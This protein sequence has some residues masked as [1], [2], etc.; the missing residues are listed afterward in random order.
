MKTWEWTRRGLVL[1]AIAMAATGAIAQGAPAHVP[2]QAFFEKPAITDL[3]LS[4]S[5]RHAALV[6]TNKDERAQLVILDTTTMKP[7]VAA[8]SPT[9]DVARIRW[10]ND[11]RLLYSL[12]DPEGK[13]SEITTPAGLFAVDR[14]GGEPRDV[15]GTSSTRSFQMGYQARFLDTSW[16]QKSD[17]VFIGYP[18]MDT[19]RAM[20]HMLVRKVDTRTGQSTAMQSPARPTDWDFDP[21]GTPRFVTTREGEG[22][23]AAYL[24]DKDRK[25]WVLV[26]R[27]DAMKGEGGLSVVGFIDDNQALVSRRPAGSD[28]YALYTW[29]LKT[30]AF[31]P[32]PLLATKGFDVSVTPI[33]SN[34]KILGLR[35]T[36]DATTTAWFDEGMKAVQAKVDQ[37][38]PGTI[39]VIGVPVRPEV[40]VVAVFSFSDTDP[41][42]Y[43]LYD[44]KAQKLIPIGQRRPSIDPSRM[45]RKDFVTYKARDGL[46]IPAWVTTPRDGKKGPRPMVVL[47][48]GG[49][50]V[51]GGHW[52]WEPMAQFLASRGYVVLEPEYRGSTGFGFNHFKASWKQ[53]GLKMQ[54][55]VAD[56]T[57]WAISKGLADPGRI[58]IAGASYG[59][60]ATLMGLVNDPDLYKCGIDWVGVTDI[61]LLYSVAWSDFN[62]EYAQY[63]MPVLVADREKDAAQIKATSPIQQA[64]RIKHPLLMAYGGRDVRV[65][66]THGIDFRDAVTKTNQNVEW[67]AYPDEG[68][69]WVMLKN[70]V[71]FWTRVEKFLAKN[72]GQ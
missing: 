50:W 11:K 46:E 51:R 38:L 21:T 29:D 40:P 19:R 64:A 39:N 33:R 47:V 18:Q 62:D 25:E 8:A 23:A 71:D 15:T 14:D 36:T 67:V 56:G 1:G 32:E 12:A 48:H 13:F 4:P 69:G 10:V 63:G 5:G 20:D 6:A 7:F 57:R 55:D 27:W 42:R 28:Y 58:C 43:A 72:I 34:G 65:P 61:D 59:G 24:W 41:G 2:V 9:L 3:S 44:T 26:H 66:M 54:D 60:Y 16:D 31:S 68:H 37:L 70:N 22:R 17:E 35:Y 30:R 53:W 49:P 52:G 45:A